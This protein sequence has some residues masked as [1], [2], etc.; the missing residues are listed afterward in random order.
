MALR[1]RRRRI[2]ELVEDAETNRKKL[3]AQADELN[4]IARRSGHFRGLWL[5]VYPENGDLA[6]EGV[7]SGIENRLIELVPFMREFLWDYLAAEFWSKTALE[8]PQ[9]CAMLLLGHACVGKVADLRYC[10]NRARLLFFPGVVIAHGQLFTDIR[11]EAA[12]F[13]LPPTPPLSRKDLAKAIGASYAKLQGDMRAKRWIF[14]VDLPKHTRLRRWRHRDE[15]EH[16]KT[17]AQIRE[18]FP[19]KVWP[20]LA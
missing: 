1:P 12:N 17:L 19:E 16:A 20:K 6:D 15:R 5:H 10:L 14:D 9:E 3:A 2:D 7:R 18:K 11:G 13:G 4:A 8:P